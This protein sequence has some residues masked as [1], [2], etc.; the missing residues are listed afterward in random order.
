MANK[1]GF[2]E[3]VEEAKAAVRFVSVLRRDDRN[4]PT[5][6]SIPGHEGK[7]YTVA[8]VRDDGEKTVRVK[9]LHS[10]NVSDICEGNYRSVCYHSFAAIMFS[11]KEAGYS[12]RIFDNEADAK[13][14][15]KAENRFQIVGHT[16]GKI[17]FAVLK[18]LP[19]KKAKK[20][21]K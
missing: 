13:K 20:E 5:I 11:A 16:S 10:G 9:C 8:L 4:R 18:R 17:F 21:S 14:A 15:G 2:N 3:R 12:V 6:L 7:R 19:E 1:K